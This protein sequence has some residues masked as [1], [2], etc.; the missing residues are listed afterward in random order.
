MVEVHAWVMMFKHAHLICVTRQEGLLSLMLQSLS[1]R[2]VRCF[3]GDYRRS[4]TLGKGRCNPPLFQEE[5]YLLTISSWRTSS[6]RAARRRGVAERNPGACDK[7]LV[8]GSDRFKEECELLTGR[9]A[10]ATKRGRP[11]GLR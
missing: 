9:R 1:H 2:D 4:G 10:K 5:R 8:L 11:A 6:A 3:K 7:E